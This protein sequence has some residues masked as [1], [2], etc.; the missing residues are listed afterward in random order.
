MNFAEAIECMK[1]KQVVRRSQ[2]TNVFV[3]MQI[4]QDISADIVPKMTSLCSRAKDLILLYP[5]HI[6]Y[7]NQFLIVNLD[8]GLATQY[9]PS[10]EDLLANDWVVIK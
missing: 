2:Q 6:H 4:P 3:T 5:K 7:H 1:G 8:N 9:I 10:T